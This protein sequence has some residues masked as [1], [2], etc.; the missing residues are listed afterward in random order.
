MKLVVAYVDSAEFES[1]REE[2]VGLGV[3]TMSVADVAGSLPEA[4]VS[5]SYRGAAIESHTRAK[6][7]VECVVGDDL[8]STVVEAVLNHP[9]KGAF[10]YVVPV[11]Q[12]HPAHYVANGTQEVEGVA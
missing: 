11:E 6:V 3:P 2:L 5:G 4:V 7:R 10:T 9:G 8:V 1:L 12:A